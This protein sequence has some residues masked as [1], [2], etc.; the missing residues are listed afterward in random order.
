MSADTASSKKKYFGKYRGIVFDNADVEQKGHIQAL[1]PDVLGLIPT[2]WALPCLPLTGMV[3]VQCGTYFLPPLDANVWMEFEHG[4]VN[5]PIWSG[6]FWG[7]QGQ[8]PIVALAGSPETAPI[9]MQTVGQNTLWLGGDPVTGITI[10]CGP[11]VSP[12]SPQIKITQAGIVITDG[13]GGSIMVALG[14]VT[15]NNGALLIK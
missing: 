7:S 8:I 2:T 11:A 1:V 5:L 9:V 14:A 4:D 6:S 15:I 3:G 13:K 12:T 10:S